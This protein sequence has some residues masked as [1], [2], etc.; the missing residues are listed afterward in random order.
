MADNRVE[1]DRAAAYLRDLNGRRDEPV[2]DRAA[3]RL[4][5]ARSMAEML[6]DRDILTP[7]K[8]LIGRFVFASRVTLLAAREK[9]GKSTFATALAAAYTR[10]EACL[11]GPLS[12]AG[13]VLW[14]GLE[15][16]EG[17]LVRRLDTFSANPA[18][19]FIVGPTEIATMADAE[20]EVERP[21]VGLVVIDSL[22]KLAEREGIDDGGNGQKW[23][24][25]MSRLTALARSTGAGMLLIHHMNKGGGY[26][27]STAIGAGV[28]I[29]V[30]M[31]DGPP[32]D[33]T[34]RRIRPKGRI[35]VPPFAVRYDAPGP[36][37][38]LDGG[39]LPPEAR[40]L[41]HIASHPGLSISAVADAIGGRYTITMALI[42]GLLEH[43]AVENRGTKERPK[44]YVTGAAETPGASVPGMPN[45]DP[46]GADREPMRVPLAEPINPRGTGAE[47]IGNRSGGNI[48]S[49]A[50]TLG[51]ADGNRW[52]AK[53]AGVPESDTADD[54]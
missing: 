21:G 30:E 31:D 5:R 46:S 51:A 44:L 26:R 12:P 16:H 18:R 19:V 53:T 11:D 22:S 48:G 8:A 14:I 7:P 17:D 35:T 52:D 37:Y 15:E 13:D 41:T 43:G 20:F 40:A 47:P 3:P 33:P 2:A 29:I 38:T 28:D 1:A 34:L 45:A 49:H 9:A 32:E 50:G 10:G 6:A 36:R 25:L 27:D 23:S 54:V 4:Y 24:P 39:E 42:R